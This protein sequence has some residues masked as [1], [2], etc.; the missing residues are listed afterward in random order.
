[1]RDRDRLIL[2]G[3]GLLLAAGLAAAE[4]STTSGAP[5]RRPTESAA[6]APA[7]GAAFDL[8]HAAWDK[9][10]KERVRDG[11]VDYR[12]L[13]A[14]SKALDDYLSSIAA[15]PPRLYS[16]WS[17]E[18][19]LAFWINVYNA[20]TLRAVLDHYPI[21]PSWLMSLRYPKNSI[22]QIPGVWDRLRFRVLGKD[23]TLDEIENGVLRKTLREPRA[24]MALVCA[25]LGCPSLR[26][27]A[28]VSARL[29]NQLDEQAILFLRDSSKFHVERREGRVYL[30][31]IFKWFAK[32]FIPN[33]EPSAGF[34]G[35]APGTRAA[36]NFIARYIAD[37]DARFV[38][39]GGYE[40][41][42]LDYDWS[43]NEVAAK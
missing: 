7:A 30:S 40:V 26:G 16:D 11:R 29:R 9:L 33:Y 42:H 38:I 18:D 17:R 6:A 34:E 23:M 2:A 43:L 15:A 3:M 1:M 4:T 27:E 19:Q 28:Y 22:R 32:D 21:K 5:T 13:K 35:P 41:L 8:S 20:L 25:S 36:L 24:H 37:D 14:D 10:L 31:R 12:G 39:A